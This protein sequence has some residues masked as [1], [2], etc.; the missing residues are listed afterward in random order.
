MANNMHDELLA[1]YMGISKVLGKFNKSWFFHF[2][3]LE[4]YPNYR[5]G[6]RFENYLGNPSISEKAFKLLQTIVK[7]AA[8]NLE[9]FDNQLGKHKSIEDRV[10]RLTSLCRLD[11]IE[12][13]SEKGVKKLLTQYKKLSHNQ[14]LNA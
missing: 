7:K 8:D 9:L 6:A 11:L 14:L 5:L 13:A 1:D 10:S 12:L 3:G 2:I 4:E